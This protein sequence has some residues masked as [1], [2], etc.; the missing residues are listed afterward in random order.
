MKELAAD[1]PETAQHA[2]VCIYCDHDHPAEELC[3]AIN[4]PQLA[5]RADDSLIGQTLGD[6][7]RIEEEIGAGGMCLVYRATQTLIGKKV[8]LK[9]L[10]PQLAVDQDIVRRFEQEATALGRLHHPHA[11]NVFDFGFTPQG[12]PFLVMDFIEGQT[13][14]DVLR[15]EVPLPVARVSKLL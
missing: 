10:R 7:Y 6:K 5:Q 8:A 3:H 11:I 13:L 2:T 9:V 1:R 14:K 12:S 4:K 15:Q